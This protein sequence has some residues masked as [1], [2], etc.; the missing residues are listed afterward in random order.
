VREGDRY[1]HP[2]V[3]LYTGSPPGPRAIGADLAIQPVKVM[4][5]NEVTLALCPADACRDRLAAFYHWHDR[6]SLSLA[7]RV[8]QHRQVDLNAIREWS[9]TEGSLEAFDEFL[10]ELQRAT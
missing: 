4:V 5:A 3:P 9:R 1:V 6:Q 7:V 10:R 8:A 2:L